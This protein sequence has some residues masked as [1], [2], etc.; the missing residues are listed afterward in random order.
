MKLPDINIVSLG[1]R[2]TS[3]I[4]PRQAANMDKNSS[5]SL[6]IK[7]AREHNLKNIDVSL[8]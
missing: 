1:D 2:T 5:P 8:L 7:G 4:Q 6:V 3:L